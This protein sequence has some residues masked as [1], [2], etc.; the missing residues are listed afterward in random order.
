MVYKCVSIAEFIE[1]TQSSGLVIVDF[2]A[3]WCGSCQLVSPQF[4]ALSRKYPGI[5]FMKVDVDEL[6]EISVALRIGAMPT[7]YVYQD[8]EVVDQLIGASNKRLEQLVSKYAS[9]S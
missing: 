7:F 4:D 3:S 1:I 6:S 9:T 5:K 2:S 8:G